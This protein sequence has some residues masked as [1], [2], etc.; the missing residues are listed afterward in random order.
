MPLLL[1]TNL[2]FSVLN[3][4]DDSLKI[5]E[6]NEWPFFPFPTSTIVSHVVSSESTDGQCFQS[7]PLTQDPPSDEHSL[8][9][10]AAAS[11]TLPA[12]SGL[13]IH[14]LGLLLCSGCVK[15]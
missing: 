7:W 15:G 14:L 5:I 6:S 8:R 10:L 11:T 3:K 1:D 13:D 9:D 4:T 2:F 12:A